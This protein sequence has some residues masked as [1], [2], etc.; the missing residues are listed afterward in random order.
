MTTSRRKFLVQ[1]VLASSGFTSAL[2]AIAE[3]ADKSL[4]NGPDSPSKSEGT[5][6]S[7]FSKCLHWLNYSDMAAAVA[8]MGF[9]GID[10]TVRPE[11]HVLPERVA[12]DLPKAVET[13]RRAGLEVYMI[14]TAI[15][16]PE[17]PHTEAIL[18]TAAKLGIPY[19][20][21]GWFPYDDKLSVLQN[22][23]QFKNRFSGLVKLNKKYGIHGDYQNHAGS[24]LG[25]AI[26]DLWLVLKE[27]DSHWIGCQYDVRH[28]MVEAANS[29]PIGLELIHSHIRTIDIKDFRWSQKD[30]KWQVETV[31]LGA[32]L[33]DF[34]KYFSL[35][36][37]YQLTGPFSIHYEYP[38]GGAEDGARQI[39]MKKEDVLSAMQKDLVTLRN[40]LDA[41]G[42]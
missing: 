10:L 30:G 37:R 40:G 28:A 25:A 8:Q 15:N 16:D 24:S 1:S 18:K 20:R 32:G 2:N 17:H 13:I 5:K 26:W 14:T 41:A 29:W 11:G 3:T 12:E 21:T 42:L 33:V 9:N 23:E 22:L 7:V 4:S 31:P 39:T 35:L 36:K 38:L 27:L 19:Y 34:P 6:I